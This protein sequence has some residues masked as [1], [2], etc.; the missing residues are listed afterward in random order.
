MASTQRSL[1][2]M[3]QAHDQLQ[4][5]LRAGAQGDAA[6][7]AQVHALTC[8]V[9]ELAQQGAATWQERCEALGEEC[10]GHLAALLA[11]A[12]GEARLR[13][14]LRQWAERAEVLQ[15]E[16]AQQSSFVAEL[17]NDQGTLATFKVE[18]ETLQSELE[19]LRQDRDRLAER[20]RELEEETEGHMTVLT[21]KREAEAEAQRRFAA[22]QHQLGKAQQEA[23]D[24]LN[25]VQMLKAQLGAGA[26]SDTDAEQRIHALTKDLAEAKATVQCL[27]VKAA[28][29][30]EELGTMEAKLLAQQRELYAA[31]NRNRQA[32]AE[33]A[34]EAERQLEEQQTELETLRAT[35]VIAHETCQTLAQEK[36]MLEEEIEGHL[37]TLQAKQQAEQRLHQEREALQRQVAALSAAAPRESAEETQETVA[38]RDHQFTRLLGER[39]EEVAYCKAQMMASNAERVEL[40]A[41]RAELQ[42]RLEELQA[43][44]EQQQR[45]EAVSRAEVGRLQEEVEMLSQALTSK[46]EQEHVLKEELRHAVA[47]HDRLAGRL[48]ELESQ[49]RTTALT[50]HQ[51]ATPSPMREDHAL[52]TEDY[53]PQPVTDVD[54]GWQ[55]PI[56]GLD[57]RESHPG[58][59]DP[60]IADENSQVKK[61]E[62]TGVSALPISEGLVPAQLAQLQG[63]AVQVEDVLAQQTNKLVALWD[64]LGNMDEILLGSRQLAEQV[65]AHL[66]ENSVLL[67]QRDRAFQLVGEMEKYRSHALKRAQHFSQKAEK[68]NAEL[69]H[70]EMMDLRRDTV[71]LSTLLEEMGSLLWA[72]S[73]QM[74]RPWESAQQV[75]DAVGIAAH[76]IEE[77]KLHAEVIRMLLGLAQ[78]SAGAVRV[79]A[80]QLLGGGAAGSDPTTEPPATTPTKVEMEERTHSP[81]PPLPPPFTTPPEPVLEPPVPSS[82]PVP[83]AK[84][85]ERPVNLERLAPKRAKL[86]Q[87]ASTVQA[88]EMQWLAGE[89]YSMAAGAAKLFGWG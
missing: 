18:W 36:A 78:Q 42:F 50:L 69:L 70:L 9:M 8:E 64:C 6:L 47:R 48:A 59:S 11:K 33:A 35:V 43:L 81:L 63:Q 28:G 49:P 73:H 12:E 55:S 3:T 75:I 45:Q 29:W 89:L 80:Q 24:H 85:I 37:R 66:Y 15:E 79:T 65:V 32:Q 54:G 46:Q 77:G 26:D 40:L 67:Q 84:F 13:A 41:A 4:Q 60:G 52:A 39:E 21:A 7:Q 44:L 20:C 57:L 2:E 68:K 38:E 61:P 76:T 5:L 62:P 23:Q 72:A 30:L 87:E 58:T 34:E 71:R 82:V 53:G 51:P 25:E 14:E 74:E 22:L 16:M 27:E 19:A 31:H 17:Q 86:Q 56:C 83:I 10:A 1:Q 88:N